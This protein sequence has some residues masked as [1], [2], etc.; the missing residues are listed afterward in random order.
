MCPGVTKRFPSKYMCIG[1]QCIPL[2]LFLLQLASR[3]YL[4]NQRN[5]IQSTF[6]VLIRDLH[7]PYTLDPG[8]LYMPV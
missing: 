5:R 2:G 8:W 1:W 7:I 3:D 4:A 6:S